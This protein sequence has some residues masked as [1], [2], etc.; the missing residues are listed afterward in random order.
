ELDSRYDCTRLLE[1]ASCGVRYGLI[2]SAQWED[3]T[4]ISSVRI[5]LHPDSVQSFQVGIGQNDLEAW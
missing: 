4:T 3:L 1:S 5:A 2:D